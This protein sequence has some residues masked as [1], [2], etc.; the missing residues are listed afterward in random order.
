MEIRVKSAFAT[1][2]IFLILLTITFSLAALLSR[3]KLQLSYL[4]SIIG[5]RYQMEF[6]KD[7]ELRVLSSTENNETNTADGRFTVLELPTQ[8]LFNL[9]Q[10]VN[11]HGDESYYFDK[12][13][14]RPAAELIDDCGK[15]L[16]SIEDVKSILFH[17]IT[18][19]KSIPIIALQPYSSLTNETLLNLSPCLRI[20]P[21]ISKT[22]LSLSSARVLSLIF[23]VDISKANTV[24]EKIRKNKIA[25]FDEL[26]SFF[27]QNNY[28]Y[29]DKLKWHDFTFGIF[30]TSRS[31]ALEENGDIFFMADL[32]VYENEQEIV[33]W[34]DLQWLPGG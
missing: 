26:V 22:N 8:G 27:K 5:H 23:E 7:V 29:N 6:K 33:S 12:N 9:S 24:L 21:K 34:S 32:F 20:S 16:A 19:K 10:I 1:A 2:T 14:L 15:G 17:F 28:S 25:N 31:V 30:Q 18:K 3:E 4:P 11:G 13:L